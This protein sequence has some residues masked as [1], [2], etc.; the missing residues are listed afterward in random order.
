MAERTRR[1][2]Q[3]IAECY[4]VQLRKKS[5][6]FLWTSLS[7]APVKAA[8]GQFSGSMAILADIT[9]RKRGEALSDGQKHVLEMISAGR[10]LE[11]TLAEL[12]NVLEAQFPEMTS[13]VLLLDPDGVH[14]RHGAAPSLPADFVRAIDGSPAGPCA[15]SCGTAV[16]RRA[17]SSTAVSA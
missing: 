8:D 13:S 4:E 12:L 10:P 15:G 5:G 2:A 17:R 6:E 7:V 1:R 9:A 16:F 3:G 14:L 11:E